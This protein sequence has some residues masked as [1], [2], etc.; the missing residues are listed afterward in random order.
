MDIIICGSGP[1]L[2]NANFN[3]RSVVY[4]AVGSLYKDLQDKIDLYFCMHSDE[5][6]NGDVEC[7]DQVHYPLQELIEKYKS[8]YFTNSISYMIAYAIYSKVDSIKLVGVDLDSKDEYT[9][10]RPSISYWCGR[11]EGEGI[12]VEWEKLNPLFLY[13]YGGDSVKLLLELLAEKYAMANREFEATTNEREKDQWAG[14]KYAIE[15]IS[16]EI[17]D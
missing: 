6:I 7:I 4:W 9:F 2:I 16:R 14:F 17:K 10:E 15:L 12:S 11:A 13:G 5:H 1:S 8:S 3:D